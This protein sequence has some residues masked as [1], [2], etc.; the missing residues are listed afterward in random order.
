MSND[1]EYLFIHF[2]A[3]WIV[4]VMCLSESFSQFFNW[5]VI[6]FLIYISTSICIMDTSPLTDI[7]VVNIFSVCGLPFYFLHLVCWWAHRL[8]FAYYGI[9]IVHFIIFKLYFIIFILHFVYFLKA[10]LWQSFIYVNFIWSGLRWSN[11]SMQDQI[12]TL[13]F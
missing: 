13:M 9:Y 11:A 6:S 2:L 7:C 12:F 4:F 10:Q 3:I 1:V 5:V 8:T